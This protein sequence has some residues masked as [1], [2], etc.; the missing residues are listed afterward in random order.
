MFRGMASDK[1]RPKEV[2][3]GSHHHLDPRGAPV[4]FD[5]GFGAIQQ[6]YSLVAAHH[7]KCRSQSFERITNCGHELRLRV[8]PVEA[9]IAEFVFGVYARTAG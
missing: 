3:N 5:H 4:S 6:D 7:A 9:A 8:R 1:R 2:L